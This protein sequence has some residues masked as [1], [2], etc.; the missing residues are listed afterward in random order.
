M[1]TSFR[2]L[3]AFIVALS[4]AIATGAIAG[5]TPSIVVLPF[6]N[7]SGVA[8]APRELGTRVAQ[9]AAERG[10]TLATGDVEPLLEQERVRY[11]DTLEEGPRRRILES[12]GATAMLTGT[13]FTFAD[14]RN[15]VVA[16]VARLVDAD[17]A[18]LWSQVI[19]VSADDDESLFGLRR[20]SDA[21][22]L[23]DVAVRALMRTFPRPGEDARST[24]GPSK[25]LLLGGVHAYRAEGAATGRRR[26]CVLPF[27][28][29]SQAGDATRIVHDTLIVRLAGDPMFEVV[30]PAELRAAARERRVGS[31]RGITTP[32]LKRIAETV[33]ATLFVQGTIYRFVEVAGRAGDPEIDLELSMLDVDSG[34]IVW[35][36]QHERRGSDY[37]G[38]LLLGAATN[39]VALTDRVVSELAESKGMT[40]PQ[41]ARAFVAARA[42][43][44]ATVKEKE[45]TSELG[46][47][48]KPGESKK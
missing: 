24:R 43:R 48:R 30:D 18:F 38:L 11:L 34:R 9:A 47:R 28:N 6:E 16:L 1:K 3:P 21:V 39:G 13:I 15:P 46:P 37:I 35:A 12:T 45:T 7:V 20:K 22:G 29:Q 26:V 36:A 14:G 8:A 41:A 44:N 23:A 10:W 2:L 42:A 19:A 17:G 33:G 5:E 31:F 27:E 40:A 25:P 4:L 32:D